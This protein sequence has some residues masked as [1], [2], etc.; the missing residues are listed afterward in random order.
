LANLS[1]ESSSEEKMSPSK[2]QLCDRARQ[3]ASLRLDGE[4]SELESALLDAHLARCGSCNAFAREA[5]GIALALRA[6]AMERLE[7]PLVVAIPPRAPRVRALQI[8]IAATLV[9][10]AA[11]LGSVLGVA[12]HSNASS[13]T[14]QGERH[15]A[16]VASGD[17]PDNLRKLR[18]A[19]LIEAGRPIPRNRLIPGESV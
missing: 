14:A 4:L 5:D 2:G 16:M 7:E 15:T 12:S 8:A 9:L 11:V 1:S 19:A 13:T 18:R 6:V 17:T 10:V 3:W